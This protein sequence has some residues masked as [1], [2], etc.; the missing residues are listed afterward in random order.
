[1]RRE[2]LVVAGALL[3]IAGSARADEI[4]LEGGRR[5][6]GTATYEGDKVIVELES[7]RISFPRSAVQKVVRT[8]SA[9]AEAQRRQAALSPNDVAGML[10]LADFCRDHELRG[11][12]R[13][14][15]ERIVARDPDHAE[16]R[17][18]LGYVRTSEGWIT[19]AELARRTDEARRARRQSELSLANQQAALKLAEAKLERER[20]ELARTRTAAT[21][22]SEPV[23]VPYPY[24]LYA[25]YTFAP[26]RGRAALSPPS[27]PPAFPIPGVRDPRDTS[28]SLPGVREPS[29]YLDGAF[30]RP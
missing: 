15:L 18:R 1:M 2:T 7:G 3:L 17:R 6:E 10:R 24:P 9:L 16:A 4:H 5:I 12:E 21:R 19:T 28:F 13:A 8:S 23:V 26:M 25:P 22:A 14:L 27:G 20:A 29:R 11:H 30:R